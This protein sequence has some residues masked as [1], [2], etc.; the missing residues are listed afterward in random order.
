MKAIGEYVNAVRFFICS[1]GGGA[2]WPIYSKKKTLFKYLSGVTPHWH[3][4]CTLD[5]MYSFICDGTLNAH[6]IYFDV[7]F[8]L[9]FSTPILKEMH[10]SL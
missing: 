4:S 1:V 6:T 5:F 9:Q 7:D 3:E 8:R 10:A 2:Q